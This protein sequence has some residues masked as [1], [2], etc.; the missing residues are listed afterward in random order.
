MDFPEMPPTHYT[1]YDC[2][3][4]CQ[5]FVADLKEI[6]GRIYDFEFDCYQVSQI[7]MS[8][9][10]S[11]DIRA[12]ARAY[13]LDYKKEI[14]LLARFSPFVD[15]AETIVPLLLP[16]ESDPVPSREL[17]NYYNERGRKMRLALKD[18]KSK[19]VKFRHDSKDFENIIIS[20]GA[21]KRNIQVI[22][23]GPKKQNAGPKQ[24]FSNLFNLEARRPK[25][26]RPLLSQ[27]QL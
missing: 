2:V 10:E 14:V 1:G 20:I 25:A 6:H 9:S 13:I 11:L 27:R 24:K 18:L 15:V 5:K 16:F 3:L 4:N 7:V 23:C 12:Q 26:Q 19:L 21:I 8:G 17:Y 22:S